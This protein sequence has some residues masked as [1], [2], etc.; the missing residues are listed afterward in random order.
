MEKTLTD[1]T[2]E[3]DLLMK[4]IETTTKK[5]L[6]NSKLRKLVEKDSL[7]KVEHSRLMDSM[8]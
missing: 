4:T 5:F 6:M 3:S 8:D 1:P 7:L 2:L